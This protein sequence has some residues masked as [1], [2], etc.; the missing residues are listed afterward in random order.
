MMLKIIA[1]IHNQCLLSGQHNFGIKIFKKYVVL[2]IF[3]DTYANVHI[4]ANH[5]KL[6]HINIKSRLEANNMITAIVKVPIKTSTA[7]GK[8][9]FNSF[10]LKQNA[11]SK[12][13]FFPTA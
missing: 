9:Y 10:L 12:R 7:T 3:G 11:S 4:I 13:W 2:V 5:S 1:I 8:E 6:S